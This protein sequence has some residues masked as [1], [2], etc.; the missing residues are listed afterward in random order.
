MRLQ[1]RERRRPVQGP[2]AGADLTGFEPATSTLTGWRALQT[3]PQ[4][5]TV[6][7]I[8][9]RHDRPLV[10]RA[11]LEPATSGLKVRCSAS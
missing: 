7:L 2:A 1:Q 9:P 6:M 3:A 4:V 10:G 11:G 8:V 5:L